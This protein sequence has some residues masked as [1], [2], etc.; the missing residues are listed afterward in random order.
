M[1][2]K[3]NRMCLKKTQ[4][5]FYYLFNK[6]VQVFNFLNRLYIAYILNERSL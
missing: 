5:F 4:F 3:R 6:N 1:R 2:Y